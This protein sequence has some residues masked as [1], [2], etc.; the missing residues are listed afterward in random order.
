MSDSRPAS[1][2]RSGVGSAVRDSRETC[3]VCALAVAPA[4]RPIGERA[5]TFF[6]A[7]SINAR[8]TFWLWK[9]SDTGQTSRSASIPPDE[10]SRGVAPLVAAPS[11]QSGTA[12]RATALAM[13]APLSR[14]WLCRARWTVLGRPALRPLARCS[15]VPLSAAN[16]AATSAIRGCSRVSADRGQLIAPL[17]T[18]AAVH[19]QTGP[20][21]LAASHSKLVCSLAI[22]HPRN[23]QVDG[24]CREREAGVG[25]E[26]VGK[27]EFA[28][29]PV[30][31]LRHHRTVGEAHLDPAGQRGHARIGAIKSSRRCG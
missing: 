19:M 26:A 9:P 12:R 3:V 31:S 14:F 25:T 2:R 10:R 13:P 7:S 18:R 4:E 17:L 8:G 1:P 15:A 22:L 5:Q 16:R 23:R 29:A 24:M 28:G 6:S 11:S 30:D 21:G 20:V 27:F